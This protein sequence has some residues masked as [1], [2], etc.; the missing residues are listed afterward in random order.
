[1]TLFTLFFRPVLLK[2]S[3][4]TLALA[5]CAN[6]P[7]NAHEDA[8]HNHGLTIEGAWAPHTG[9]RTFSAAVYLNITN[10]GTEADTLT[11]MET[12][13]AAM[14]MLHQSKEV[15]GIMTMDH[16]AELQIPVGETIKLSPGAYHIM[17]TRLDVPLKRGDVFPL[18]LS[19]QNAG[20]VTIVVEITGIGGPS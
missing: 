7:A 2:V 3:A 6:M 19:F 1:M 17:L 14:A 8:S 13:A 12:P 10:T 4:A 11:G 18:T 16:V 5:L 9:K 15:D 20:D